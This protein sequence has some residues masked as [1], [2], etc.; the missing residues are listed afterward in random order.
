MKRKEVSADYGAALKN[1]FDRWEYLKEYGCS[2]PTFA[3]GQGTL[4]GEK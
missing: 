2:D 4:C 3:D 1:C